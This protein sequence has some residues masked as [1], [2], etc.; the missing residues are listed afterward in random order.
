MDL[1]DGIG[2]LANGIKSTQ[3]RQLNETKQRR[4][5][6]M[7]IFGEPQNAVG[8]SSNSATFYWSLSPD[9]DRFMRWEFKL[10]LEN[11]ITHVSSEGAITPAELEIE[12]ANLSVSGNN[13][14]PNPHKHGI[15]PNPHTHQ[16]V[17]GITATASQVSN[18]KFELE[19]V[20]ITKYLKAQYPIDI[21][22]NGVYPSSDL[23]D[24]YDILEAVDHLDSATRTSLLTAGLKTLKISTDGGLMSAKILT[25]IKYSQINR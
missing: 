6:V 18:V 12:E 5:S 3:I 8:D 10:I 20:D 13:I 2:I 19:G 9:K 1:Q 11:F 17:Q 4:Q 25:Y 7:D 21:T 22:S 15:T 24:R 23:N 16:I 14:T